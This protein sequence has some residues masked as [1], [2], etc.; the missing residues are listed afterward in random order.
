[1]KGHWMADIVVFG[2]SGGIGQ[3]LVRS[4]SADHTLLGT[5]NT[6]DPDSLV[7][8][9][10]YHPLD[11]TDPAAV[12]A[13]VAGVQDQL[14][15]PVLVY[16]PGVSPDATAHKIADA[17]WQRA[18]S[19]NLSGA[20]HVTR[21]M[22]P[23]MRAAKWGRIVY[24]SSV[25][26][27]RGTPGTLAY[28]A[29]KAALGAMARVVSVENAKRGIT[30]NALALGYYNVGIIKAVPEEFL[31][32]HVLPQIPQHRLGDPQNITEAVQFLIR[33]DYLTGATLDIN[34]GMIGA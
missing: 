22:L 33:S 1:M 34:G 19:T 28:S 6:A 21:A 3:H 24:L 17:D 30:A 29:T 4:L 16:T 2:A 25:L 20:M 11:V 15:R 14:Q 27:R 32:K 8:G 18:L 5:Y 31:Q 13:F 26:A 12:N 9:A 10:A 23:T 7:E